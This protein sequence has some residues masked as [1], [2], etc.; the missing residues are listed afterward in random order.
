MCSSGQKPSE[1]EGVGR[2]E[3]SGAFWPP[4]G[5]LKKWVPKIP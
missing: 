5:C 1:G 2:S 3:E 4:A